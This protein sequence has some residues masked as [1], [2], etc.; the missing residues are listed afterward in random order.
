MSA[1]EAGTDALPR[2]Q[3]RTDDQLE[4]ARG[5][6]RHGPL[7]EGKLQEGALVGEVGELGAADAGPALKVND[8]EGLGCSPSAAR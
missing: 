4:A 1:L 8:V 5:G 7:G 6:S 2:Q 3:A